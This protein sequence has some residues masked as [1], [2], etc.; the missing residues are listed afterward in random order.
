MLVDPLV[1]PEVGG[2]HVTGRL[3]A[4]NSG[5][6][7]WLPETAG[8]GAVRVGARVLSGGVSVWE[9]RL[10]LPGDGVAQ[11]AAVSVPVDVHLPPAV[12]GAVLE[13]DLVSEDAAWFS[14]RGTHPV[15]LPIPPTRT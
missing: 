12:V 2:V 9:G 5:E 10:P 11:G 14:T 8:T 7:F 15:R 6:S 4:T 1:R 13:L 3:D